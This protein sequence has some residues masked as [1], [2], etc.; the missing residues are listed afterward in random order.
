MI[1]PFSGVKQYA[2][3]SCRETRLEINQFTKL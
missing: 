1:I 3:P 2:S